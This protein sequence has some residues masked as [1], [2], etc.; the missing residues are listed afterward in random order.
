MVNKQKILEREL[1]QCRENTYM[2]NES[3]NTI[4]GELRKFMP[5][6]VYI[7]ES[8]AITYISY[9]RRNPTWEKLKNEFGCMDIVHKPDGVYLFPVYT[10]ITCNHLHT[11]ILKKEHQY[12]M[13]E[14]LI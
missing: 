4:V 13:D 7:A 9:M 10:T 3:L 14:I 6:K 2:G 12:G 11:L 1:V 5:A 8:T